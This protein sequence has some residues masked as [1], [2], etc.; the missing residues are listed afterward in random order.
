MQELPNLIN[1]PRQ[2][3]GPASP[4]RKINMVQYPFLL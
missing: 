4:Q 1:V 2:R 3:L